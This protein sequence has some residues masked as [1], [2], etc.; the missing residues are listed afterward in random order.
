MK[1][2]ALPHRDYSVPSPLDRYTRGFPLK[3]R[4][5]GKRKGV[6][7]RMGKRFVQKMEKGGA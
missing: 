3:G 7:T 1:P 5:V 2:R 6:A 4:T